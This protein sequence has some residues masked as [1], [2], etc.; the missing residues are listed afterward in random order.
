MYWPRGPL[1]TLTGGDLN[2]GYA[3]APALVALIETAFLLFTVP[4]G[5]LDDPSRPYGYCRAGWDLLVLRL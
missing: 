3:V 2:S 5:E 1:H 4:W